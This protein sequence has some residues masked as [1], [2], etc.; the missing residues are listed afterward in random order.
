MNLIRSYRN[1]QLMFPNLFSYRALRNLNESVLNGKYFIGFGGIYF[2]GVST[3]S[4][5]ALVG[6]KKL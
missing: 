5:D 1:K 6:K 4:I 3:I 2:E